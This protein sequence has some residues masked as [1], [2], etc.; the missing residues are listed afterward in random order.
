ML[1][2]SVCVYLFVFHVQKPLFILRLIA[3]SFGSPNLLA[4][5]QRDCAKID[6]DF[7][8]CGCGQLTQHWFCVDQV[9]DCV[10]YE[11]L[12][13]DTIDWWC[14]LMLKSQLHPR[15]T[16][17]LNTNINYHIS[18]FSFLSF[19]SPVSFSLPHSLSLSPTY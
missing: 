11:L 18:P 4:D 7:Q 9:D 10:V 1:Q 14:T 6:G 3:S 17:W 19:L 8:V 16:I 2:S 5:H 13:L 12:L 15:E